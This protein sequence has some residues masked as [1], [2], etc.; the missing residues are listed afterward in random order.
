MKH[1]S[2]L[3]QCPFWQKETIAAI[4]C[5]IVFSQP[6]WFH[7]ATGDIL[8]FY[9]ILS[10]QK[11]T[12]LSLC[13]LTSHQANSSIFHSN[14]SQHTKELLPMTNCNV[15]TLCPCIHWGSALSGGLAVQATSICKCVYWYSHGTGHKAPTKVCQWASYNSQRVQHQQKLYKPWQTIIVQRYLNL[16]RK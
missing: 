16:Q 7:H 10:L 3:G 9:S 8:W 11:F 12:K 1:E 14:R 15:H 4:E 5:K 2:S 6:N 13:S